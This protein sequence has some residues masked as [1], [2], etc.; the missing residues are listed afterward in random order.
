MFLFKIANI[1]YI[2]FYFYS[3]AVLNKLQ[4]SNFKLEQNHRQEQVKLQEVS[5]AT[6]VI[7]VTSEGQILWKAAHMSVDVKIS[8]LFTC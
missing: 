7:W 2:Y 6:Q 5:Y 8:F 3:K 1:F 4:T